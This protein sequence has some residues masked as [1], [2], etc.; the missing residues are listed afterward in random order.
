MLHQA[1]LP[2]PV[3]APNTLI[4]TASASSSIC[5]RMAVDGKMSG[6]ADNIANKRLEAREA[7]AGIRTS[8]SYFSTSQDRMS[9]HLALIKNSGALE[10]LKLTASKRSRRRPSSGIS[11]QPERLRSAGHPRR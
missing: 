3:Q 6:T 11:R 1:I 2:E 5:L 8:L 9:S 4:N 7:P 10:M